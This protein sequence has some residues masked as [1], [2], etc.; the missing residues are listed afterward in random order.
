MVMVTDLLDGVPVA[1]IRGDAAST[2]V[3]AV[4]FDSRRAV[5][6]AM[7]CCVPGERTDGPK[8]WL[9]GRH[10]CCASTSSTSR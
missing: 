2:V 5:D 3:T 10:R 6:G 8:R 7:F 9:G 1:A 4:E